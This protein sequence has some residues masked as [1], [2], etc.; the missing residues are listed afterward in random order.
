MPQAYQVIPIGTVRHT[1]AQTWIEIESPFLPAMDG[2]EGFSHIN[3]FFWFH[4]NDH[5]EGRQVLKVHPRR[6]ETKPLTGVF[7]THSPLRPNLIGM[8]LCRVVSLSSPKI[9]IDQIDA[10]D[11][12]PV[13][14]IKCYIPS[15]RSFQNLRLPDWV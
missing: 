6:D 4:E 2:L 15:S 11:G 7:A 13:L 8:T 10:L 5:P 12:T 14:D 3:V 9:I 1:E